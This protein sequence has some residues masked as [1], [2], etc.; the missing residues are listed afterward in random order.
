M[1]Y[2]L[3][4][5]RSSVGRVQDCD[6]C[7]RG[8]DPRRSPHI[9]QFP[10]S[11]SPPLFVIP[12]NIPDMA[13]SAIPVFLIPRPRGGESDTLIMA[14]PGLLCRVYCG[15]GD[16]CSSTVDTSVQDGGKYGVSFLRCQHGPPVMYNPPAFN[17]PVAQL[18][19]ASAF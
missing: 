19:R 14:V 3:N 16:K 5:D 18:D 1:F 7:C 9:F 2:K 8:F 11:F 12:E 4:G 15:A 10:V 17:A 6:S 13:Q